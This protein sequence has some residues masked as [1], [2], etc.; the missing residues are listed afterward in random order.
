MTF[1]VRQEGEGERQSVVSKVSLAQDYCLDSGSL[2][3]ESEWV[4][5]ARQHELS[6]GFEML[7]Q[8]EWV[9]GEESRSLIVSLGDDGEVFQ[10]Q[11]GEAGF[12]CILR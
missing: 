8:Q 2:I 1:L 10:R 12:R 7:G 5:M 4:A 3:S 6:E 9:V 11:E